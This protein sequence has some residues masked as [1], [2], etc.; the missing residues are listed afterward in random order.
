MTIKHRLISNGVL[1]TTTEFNEVD[2]PTIEIARDGI[3]AE[4]IDEVSF[5]PVPMRFARD[6]R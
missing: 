4:E 6:K 1:I 5:T 2:K 3:Y